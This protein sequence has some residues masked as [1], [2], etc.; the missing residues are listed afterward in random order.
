MNIKSY[1]NKDKGMLTQA[2]DNG[3]NFCYSFLTLK[4]SPPLMLH[5]GSIYSPQMGNGGSNQSVEG[6][7]KAK[8]QVI[9]YLMRKNPN[10][11]VFVFEHKTRCT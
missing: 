10:I 11:F 3:E 2:Y 6:I 9:R 8:D 5:N 4:V 7:W 1:I